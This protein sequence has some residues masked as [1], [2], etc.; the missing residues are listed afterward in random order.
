MSQVGGDTGGKSGLLPYTGRTS[1]ASHSSCGPR[2]QAE[3]LRKHGRPSLDGGGKLRS[4]GSHPPLGGPWPLP[5]PGL[6]SHVVPMDP[7]VAVAALQLQLHLRLHPRNHLLHA[8]ELRTREG[9]VSPGPSR[10]HDCGSTS[11]L[12]PTLTSQ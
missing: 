11:W 8:A 9:H 2:F 7:A 12:S 10:G 6:T 4:P 3:K 5:R 1:S